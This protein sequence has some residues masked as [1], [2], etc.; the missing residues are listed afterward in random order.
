MIKFSTV[1]PKI[2]YLFYP[3]FEADPH[4][5][6]QQS[7]QVD[8]STKQTSHRDYQSRKN[9][10]VLHRKETFVA[11]THPLHSKFAE[12]TRQQDSLGLLNNS[13]EI[14]TRFGWQQRLEAH[15]IELH[16]HQLA[17]PLPTSSNRTPPKIDRHKAALVR[18]ALSKPVR[19]A[20]EAGLFTP[21]TTFFDY[22][23]GYG[24]D[25]QRIAEQGFSGSGWDP[26]YQTNTPCV[27]ADVVNLGYV[28]NVIENPL[29]RREALINAWALTQKVLIVSAQVLVEDRIR[30]TVMYSDGVIT[31]RNTFQKNYE[32][33]ELKV[34]IDQVLEVDAIPVALGIYFVFRDEAQAQSFRASRFRSRATTPRVKASVKRFEQ[35]KAMLAPLMAFFTE[36]GRLPIEEELQEFAALQS[37][38]GT[39]RRAFQV[40]LQATEVQEWDAISEKRRQDLLVYL[41]L[42]H[43]GERPKLRHLAPIVQHDIKALFGNYQQACTAA[44]LMLLSLGNLEVMAERC[45]SS[46]IGKKLSNSLWVHVSVLDALDPLLRLYEGCAS[47][48]IGRPEEATVVKFHTSKPKISYL[49]YPNFDRDPHP[50]LRTSMQIDLQDLHVSYRDYDPEDNPPVLHQKEL[51]VQSDYPLY[52]KFAKLSRQE[53]DWGLLD[54]FGKIRDRRGWQK[55]LEEHC[56]GLKGHRVVWQKDAD[57][58]RVKL[59]RSAIREKK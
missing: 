45:K 59:V 28:I 7:I 55:C 50:C 29:E 38:F 31:R 57:P 42:S 3:D 18:T 53:A 12:L 13:R 5:A 24:G 2:S 41:A 52:E 25:V 39:L 37:E 30:G 14:G 46:E 11:P 44:D 48:T 34:Y 36:R 16:G 22:G 40:V 35:F 9:P 51:L 10:P 17:C 33:E 43:F 15:K 21:E 58:Y 19:S 54:D 20:L 23:C 47:R 56:A 1:Q 4:P 49:F 6:L 8:L 27:S 32:Q 26:Y